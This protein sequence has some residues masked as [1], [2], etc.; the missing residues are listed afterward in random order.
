MKPQLYSFLMLPTEKKIVAN[1]INSC[2]SARENDKWIFMHIFRD[3]LWKV[4]D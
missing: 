3:V 4:G 2:S 1:K